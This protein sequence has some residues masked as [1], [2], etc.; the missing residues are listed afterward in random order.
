MLVDG[1][2]T[3]ENQWEE[4]IERDFQS[5]QAMI[6]TRQKRMLPIVPALLIRHAVRCGIRKDTNMI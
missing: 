1:E 4:A 5:D 3:G 6:K 2:L